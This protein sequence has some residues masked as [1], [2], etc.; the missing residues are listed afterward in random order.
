MT[1]RTNIADTAMCF[2]LNEMERELA[3]LKSRLGES[4]ES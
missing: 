3:E 4:D 1:C 2:H